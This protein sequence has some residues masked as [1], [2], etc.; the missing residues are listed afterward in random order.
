MKHYYNPMSRALS[1]DW[2]LKELDAQHQ[3]INIDFRTENEDLDL[4]E[5]EK[6]KLMIEEKIADLKKKND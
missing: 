2:M 5:L 1:T 6:M 4:T 3:Q